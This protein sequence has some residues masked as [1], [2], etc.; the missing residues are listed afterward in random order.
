MPFSNEIS[1]TEKHTPVSDAFVSAEL[2]ADGLIRR[3]KL[4]CDIFH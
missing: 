1:P 2:L 3:M 4:L